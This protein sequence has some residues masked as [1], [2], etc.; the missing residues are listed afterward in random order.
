LRRPS[1]NMFTSMLKRALLHIA[2]LDRFAGFSG[3]WRLSG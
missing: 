1:L 3:D 2:G